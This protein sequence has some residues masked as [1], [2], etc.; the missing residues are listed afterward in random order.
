MQLTPRYESPA[1]LQLDGPPGDPSVP[2]LRQRRRLA[3]TLATLDEEQWAAPSRCAGWSVKDVVIHLISTNQFW[4][5]SI[6]SGRAGKPTTFLATFDPVASPAATV[7]GARSTP[8]TEVLARFTETIDPVA[9]AVA[10]LAVDDWFALGEAPPG[11]VALDAVAWHALWDAWVHER[12]I[13]LP[14]GLPPT[15]EADEVIGCLRYAAALGPA[16]AIMMGATEPLTIAVEAT[17]PA[18]AFVVEATDVVAVRDRPAPAASTR[19]AGAAID[20]LEAL[21]CRAPLQPF[22]VDGDH[23]FHRGLAAVF[24]LPT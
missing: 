22:L 15:D 18:V 7:D 21:S 17:D 10:G 13:L 23:A 3:A 6:A 12:D 14:L 19:L 11:H 8:T 4:A 2:L 16:L 9:D 1:V 20:L 5:I 24:D